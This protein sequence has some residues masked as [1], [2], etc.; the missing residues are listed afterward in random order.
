MLFTTNIKKEDYIDLF[1]YDEARGCQ[2]E[3]VEFALDAYMNHN[4]KFVI[5]EAGTGVGKSAIGLT[6][7]RYLNNRLSAEDEFKSGAYFLTTQKILQEQYI[8]DFGAPT[9]CM[10][11]IKSSANYKCKFN[12]KNTCADSLRALKIA[13]KSSKFFRTCAYGCNYKKAK[14]DFIAGTEGVTNFSYFLAETQYAGK[15]GPRNVLIVDEAHNCDLELS[16]FIE[17]AITERFAKQALKLNMPIIKTQAQAFKWIKE[18]YEPK[19]V[20][21]LKHVEMMVGKYIDLK[22]KI[23]EFATIAKRYEMLDKHACKLHRFL[24]IYDKENWVVNITEAQGQAGQRLEFKPIDVSPYAHEMLFNLGRKVLLMSATILDKEGFCRLLGIPIEDVAF[25][26]IPSPFPPENKPILFS[27]IG[28]MSA[29]N[30]DKTLPN[31]VR[32]IKEIFKN[33]PKEKGII[34]C[35]SYK[36]A[37]YIKRNFRSSRLLTHDSSNREEVLKEHIRS[38]KHTVLLSPSM[39]E[40]VDLKDDISRFQIICKVPYPYLGD[41]LIKKRMHKWKWWYPLQTAKKIVQSVGRSIRSADDFAVTYILD[42]DWDRFYSRNKRIFP[43]D[44]KKCLK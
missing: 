7:A 38:K 36:T 43:E 11:S 18:V 1:P 39:T 37:N 31:L 19:L 42:G 41:K 33:H 16:K 22:D 23:K 5:I 15:L 9:G 44:F 28:S 27:S 14:E 21:H 25:I 8:N 12:T 4:K 24:K 35:H 32:A 17:I 13:D 40:G 30:I 26:S 6:V 29:N 34:H 3:S 2:I 10:K 20:S